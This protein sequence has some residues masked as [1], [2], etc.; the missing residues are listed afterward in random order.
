MAAQEHHQLPPIK[1]AFFSLAYG[2]EL[3]DHHRPKLRPDAEQIV[4]K[5]VVDSKCRLDVV[6]L[7]K[8]DL[9][10]YVENGVFFSV[11][12]VCTCRRA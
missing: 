10:K 8:S 3:C 11:R 6:P 12:H 7:L 2:E 9:F 5:P 4:N 1:P